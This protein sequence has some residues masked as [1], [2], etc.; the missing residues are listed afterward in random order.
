MSTRSLVRRAA[1]FE[2]LLEIRPSHLCFR[3]LS[4]SVVA[5]TDAT[6]KHAGPNRRCSAARTKLV[7]E[8]VFCARFRVATT[9]GSSPTRQRYTR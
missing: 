3:S 4:I 1:K 5:L 6:F 7:V 8:V 2:P 9:F